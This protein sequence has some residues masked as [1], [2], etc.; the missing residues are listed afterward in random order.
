MVLM[1]VRETTWAQLLAKFYFEKPKF[2][3]GDKHQ[4]FL[5][6]LLALAVCKKSRLC[7]RN[8]LA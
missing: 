6:R 5:E 8:L 1:S 7:Q 3:N 4:F 2:H